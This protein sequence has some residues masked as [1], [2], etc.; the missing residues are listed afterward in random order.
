MGWF[1]HYCWVVCLCE[2]HTDQLH[3]PLWICIFVSMIS[4]P[5]LESCRRETETDNTVVVGRGGVDDYYS[6]LAGD[7]P[8]HVME[9]FGG[10]G[11]LGG[12]TGRGVRLPCFLF[13]IDVC[14][15]DHQR[16]RVLWCDSSTTEARSGACANLVRT[17][18]PC[19]RP[20]SCT[21]E[22]SAYVCET[23]HR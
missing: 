21:L 9:P 19:N 16:P 18:M 7:F 11:G 14:G 1:L 15:T 23:T 10:L 2:C 4:A 8:L 17:V 5:Y 20:H 13:Y 12:A 22:G 6:T 3:I